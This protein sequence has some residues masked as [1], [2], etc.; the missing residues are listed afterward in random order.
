MGKEE[1][2]KSDQSQWAIR[3]RLETATEHFFQ[4]NDKFFLEYDSCSSLSN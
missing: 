2:G 3:L 4:M 1:R